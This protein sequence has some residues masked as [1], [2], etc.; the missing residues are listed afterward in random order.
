MDFIDIHTHIYPE[1]IA[2][3][4]A[5]AICSYY[6]LTEGMTGTSELL[7]ERE[8]EAGISKAVLLPVATKASI[9]QSINNFILE[10]QSAHE[11]FIA[12]ATVHAEMEN[13]VAET[14]EFLNMGLHGIKIH[15]DQQN[16]PI[17]DERLFPLYDFLQGLPDEKKV[18]IL[19]HCGDPVSNLSHPSRLKRV[20][21]LFPK[22][23]VIA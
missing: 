2:K 3:K 16:F 19:F 7:L 18:P 5:D 9:V 12:F 22:L 13:L 15:P 14:E 4:A 10:E 8:K 21:H 1:K 17:D 20:L 6:H 23:K 11:Q